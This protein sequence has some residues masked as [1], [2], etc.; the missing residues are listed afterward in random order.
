[1]SSDSTQSKPVPE[2]ETF[3]NS[4]NILDESKENV[5][6]VANAPKILW[7]KPIDSFFKKHASVEDLQ[8]FAGISSTTSDSLEHIL[9]YQSI[10]YFSGSGNSSTDSSINESTILRR[11]AS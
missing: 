8:S 2:A 7:Q 5:P 10:A 6:S 9:D 3:N 4:N 11:E 1:M